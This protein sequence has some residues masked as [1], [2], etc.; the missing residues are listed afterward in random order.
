VNCD[1]QCHLGI[2]DCSTRRLFVRESIQTCLQRMYYLFFIYMNLYD[3][4]LYLYFWTFGY[5]GW[6]KDDFIR[7]MNDPL[8]P[9]SLSPPKPPAAELWQEADSEKNVHHL[10][11][12]TFDT[13]LSQQKSALVMFYAPCMSFYHVMLRVC[14]FFM[15]YAPYTSFYSVLCSIYVILSCSVL[16]IC[17][18]ILFYAPCMSFYHVLCCFYSTIWLFCVFLC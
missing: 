3:T 15:F 18:L 8:S 6:Q 9:L 1:S 17:N 14:H 12:W 11:D 16:P 7:F 4:F 10:V 5:D 13:V 2:A